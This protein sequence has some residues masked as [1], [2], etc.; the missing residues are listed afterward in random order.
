[1]VKRIV[2]VHGEGAAAAV[3]P[4]ITVV[5]VEGEPLTPIGTVK[6]TC[7]ASPVGVCVSS[8]L[9]LPR[10]I[11]PSANWGDVPATFVKTLKLQFR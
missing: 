9:V 11:V 10:T 2:E 7:K 1:M 4:T 6:V 3:L 8:V 5:N